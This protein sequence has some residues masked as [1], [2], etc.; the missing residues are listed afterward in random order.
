MFIIG[1]MSSLVVVSIPKGKSAS[2]KQASELAFALSL[3]LREAISTGRPVS[4][5]HVDGSN[6][7]KRYF[8]GEWRSGQFSSSGFRKASRTDEIIVEV[9]MLGIET[10]L[11]PSDQENKRAQSPVLFF[12][13]GEATPADIR[14]T[15]SDYDALYRVEPDGKVTLISE[16]IR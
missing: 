4:W 12:P 6:T 7:F 15:S 10:Q 1:L 14:I 8:D 5:S 2:Q 9:K 16:D 3:S 11:D 13:T